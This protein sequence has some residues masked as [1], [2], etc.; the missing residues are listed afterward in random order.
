MSKKNRKQA[1]EKKSNFFASLLKAPYVVIIVLALAVNAQTLSFEFVEHDDNLV[2][3]AKDYYGNLS[4]AGD[5]F[6]KGYLG[7]GYYRPA[8]TLSFMLD[9]AVGG[10]EPLF[11]HLTN[12]LLHILS[13][14]FL[15]RFLVLL[16]LN[17][18]FSLM[19]AL[20]FSVHPLVTNALHWIPGRN[21]MLLLMFSLLSFIFYIKLFQNPKPARYLLHFIF[22]LAALFSKET[23]LLL[24]FIFLSYTVILKKDYERR[25]LGISAGLWAAGWLIWIYLRSNL[26]EPFFHKGVD[27]FAVLEGVRV[28][29]ESLA[30]FLFP[31]NIS[32]LASYN[33]ISLALGAAALAAM[34]YFTYRKHNRISP[35][36]TCGIIWLILGILPSVLAPSSSLAGYFDYLE[37]RLYFIIPAVFILLKE[38]LPDKSFTG[39]KKTSLIFIIILIAY[40]LINFTEA[41]NYSEPL[42]YWEKAVEEQPE[43]PMRRFSLSITYGNRRAVSSAEAQ[44]RKAIELDSANF[45]YYNN[46]GMLFLRQN[47]IDSAVK[48]L[49]A[50]DKADSARPDAKVN[51]SAAYGQAGEYEKAIP[52]LLEAKEKLDTLNIDVIYNLYYA[53]TQTGNYDNAKKYVDILFEKDSD[54]N[55]RDFYQQ[56]GAKYFEEGNFEK[57]IEITKEYTRAFPNDAQA[58]NNLGYMHMAAGNYYE[59]EKAL[60]KALDID[61]N[62]KIAYSN[63]YELYYNRMKDYEKAKALLIKYGLFQE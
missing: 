53:Y 62:K 20:L 1:E 45:D 55:L 28:L 29:P 17:K 56:W 9:T 61:P 31:F 2:S 4:N 18:T 32:V 40:S 48:Y 33:F 37:T 54:F 19:A 22:L 58:F 10:G 49:E 16:G 41:K 44:L 50:A 63:L 14:C 23:A 11:Y 35:L 3:L 52:I 57:A 43:D 39:G 36:F 21:D 6:T 8:V 24:P 42:K 12:L 46:L 13:A 30:K 5:A 27:I 34:L 59:A 26:S 60:Q 7:S 47:K 51:L 25:T 38:S 15:F